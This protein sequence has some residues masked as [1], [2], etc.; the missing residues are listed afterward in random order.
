V[1]K[2]TDGRGLGVKEE[3][4]RLYFDVR[5]EVDSSL[6]GTFCLF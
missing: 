2:Q 6:M 5:R 3:K 1:K 4:R